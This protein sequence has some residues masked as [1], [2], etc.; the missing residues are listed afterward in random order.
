MR[1]QSHAR[2]ELQKQLWHMKCRKRKH[3][4]SLPF[5]NG[6]GLRTRDEIMPA[7]C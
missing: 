7:V 3:D 5:M 2:A 1:K 6:Q 4:A